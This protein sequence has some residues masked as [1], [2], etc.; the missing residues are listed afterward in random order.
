MSLQPGDPQ[1]YNFEFEQPLNQDLNGEEDEEG[2][3]IVEFPDRHC[4]QIP[5]HCC[6]L[7]ICLLPL[8]LPLHHILP[9][10]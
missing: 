1:H 4:I 5:R 6:L 8:P 9:D 7:T 10:H 3:E 2:E